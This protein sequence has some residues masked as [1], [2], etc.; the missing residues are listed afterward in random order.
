MKI[1]LIQTAPIFGDKAA[2]RAQIEQLIGDQM[3]DLWVMPELA[4][5]GYEFRS[6]EEAMEL[7]EEIPRGESSQWLAE[8][9][10]GRHC[11]AV[12]GVAEHD[13]RAV[14]NSAVIAGP[15]GVIGKYRKIHLFDREF[16]RFD[17]G[18]LPL[19]VF[20]IGMARVGVMICFDWRYP[21]AARTLT[22]MGSQIIAHPSNLVMPYAQAAMVT[23]A[24][25]NRVFIITANR[26]GTEDRAGRSVTFTG[27]SVMVNP[28]GDTVA[29]ASAGETA[30][31]MVEI[32]PRQADDKRVNRYNDLLAGRRPEFYLGEV[33]PMVG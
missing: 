10:K 15:Q 5:T 8:L 14:Y 16:N 17:P 31:L 21:E 1:G 20:D 22:L 12:L 18:D 24:L 6:R 32:D 2:N 33:P 13:G 3:A 29:H 25:E 4:L 30:A 7:A 28:N 9:C 23:R 19:Q 11:H 27:G 26:V